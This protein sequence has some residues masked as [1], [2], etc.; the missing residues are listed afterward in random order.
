M[1]IYGLEPKPDD[2]YLLKKN[3]Y[4]F[5]ICGVETRVFLPGDP[6]K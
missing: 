1:K 2:L 6:V 3:I 5:N 4:F